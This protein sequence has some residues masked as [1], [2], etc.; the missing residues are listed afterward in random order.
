MSGLPY[1]ILLQ[2]CVLARDISEDTL[3][4]ISLVNRTWY[5]A[6]ATLIYDRLTIKFSDSSSLDR[7]VKRVLEKSQRQQYLAHVRRLDVLALPPKVRMVIDDEGELSYGGTDILDHLAEPVDFVPN[8]VGPFL[9]RQLAHWVRPGI[10]LMGTTPGYYTEKNWQPLVLLVTTLGHLT[11]L[12]YSVDNMFPVC[13]LRAIHEHHPTCK[14][15]IWSSQTLSLDKP[16]LGRLSAYDTPRFNDPFDL[17]VLRSPCLHAIGIDYAVGERSHQHP[18]IPLIA[19]A[20]NLKHIRIRLLSDFFGRTVSSIN[21]EWTDFVS[22][23]NPVPSAS[24]ASV[25]FSPVISGIEP[26]LLKLG[27]LM[28]LSQLRSLEIHRIRHP[29]IMKQALSSIVNLETLF[30]HVHRPKLIEPSSFSEIMKSIFDRFKPLKYLCIRAL[31]DLSL[32][33]DILIRHGRSLRGLMIEPV[34]RN[35]LIGHTATDTRGYIYPRFGHAD[36][37]RLA[38]SCPHLEELRIPVQRSKGDHQECQLYRALGKFSMLRSLILDLGCNPPQAPDIN[39]NVYDIYTL[40]DALINAAV[41]ES[42]AMAI[43]DIVVSSQK[44]CALRNLRCGPFGGDVFG[45]EACYVFQRRSRSFLVSRR[46]FHLAEPPEVTEIGKEQR[47]ADADWSTTYEKRVGLEA[48][49]F[50]IPR[51]ITRTIHSIWP[52]GLYGT[53]WSTGWNSFPLHG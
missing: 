46:G 7:A 18:I 21:E 23:L 40:K 17:E 20:P 6:A 10:N 36:V 2:I 33:D 35:G 32:L 11:E 13:L 16:G 5:H 37:E 52:P 1:E 38:E 34:S 29:V 30:I 27:Q 22:S 28:D 24:L 15:N 19:M 9:E 41:D 8:T 53:D 3:H 45:R 50:R 12:H 42:L 51:W 14:L 25:S 47:E 39:E 44:T 49:L 48:K 4:A 31:D 26:T 43:W